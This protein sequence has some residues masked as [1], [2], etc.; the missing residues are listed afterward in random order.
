MGP[1]IVTRAILVDM[2]LLKGVP[3]LEPTTPIDPSDLEAWEKFASVKIGSGD[4]V[5]IRVGRWARRAKVGPW[6]A[7]REGRPA[8]LG[9]ALAE[10][11]GHRAAR[12]RLRQRRPAVRHD[13]RHGRRRK[14]SHSHAGDCSE[15]WEFLTTVQFTRLS[16]GTASAFNALGVF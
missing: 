2:P 8:R 11:A 16:G 9:D 6:N 13:W 4:A 14:P 5:F 10:A 12:Q 7:A 15:R 3:Y 1:G